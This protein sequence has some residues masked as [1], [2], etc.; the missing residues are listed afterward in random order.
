MTDYVDKV[1]VRVFANTRGAERDIKRVTSKRRQTVIDAV[2]DDAAARRALKKLDDSAVVEVTARTEKARQKLAELRKQ[3]EASGDKTVKVSADITK[4]RAT[5]AQLRADLA[6]TEDQDAKVKIRADIKE[7][8]GRIQ[9]LRAN[10]AGIRAE[11]VAVQVDVKQA[12][13]ELRDLE[14][15][16]KA[17]VQAHAETVA[18]RVEMARVARDRIVNLI[19]RVKSSAAAAE[20]SR[21]IAGL[22]GLK[23]LNRWRQSL[24]N[25]LENLPQLTLKL[26]TFGLAIAGLVTPLMAAASAVAPLLTSLAAMAPLALAYVPLIAA[27]KSIGAVGKLAFKDLDKATS[28]GGKRMHAALEGLKKDFDSVRDVVQDG[29]FSSRFVTTMERLAATVL[30]QVRAGFAGIS[31]ALSSIGVGVMEKLTSQLAGGA[32]ATFFAN[33]SRALSEARDGVIGFTSGLAQIAIAGSQVLPDLGAKLSEIGQRFAA[34]TQHA[35]IAGMI[36]SAAVQFGFLATAAGNLIGIVRGIFTAMDTGRSSG[37]ESL[38]DTLGRIRGVVEG[39]AFQTAMRTVFT[40]AADGARALRE[41]LTPIGDSLAKLAP[42]FGTILATAGGALASML[43]GIT[44]ALAQPI[45]QN[46]IRAALE[47]IAALATSIP[48]GM[49]GAAVGILG[50]AI[51]QIA[52]LVTSLLQSVAPLLPPILAAISSLIPP[53]VRLVQGVLPPLMEVIGALVPVIESLAPAFEALVEP[54]TAIVTM[55]AAGLV[56]ALQLIAKLITGVVVPV[57]QVLGAA[58]TTAVD[59]VTK[60]LSGDWQGAWDAAS[61]AVSAAAG[62]ILGFLAGLVAKALSAIA[63]WASGLVAKVGAMWSAA[64]ALVSSGVNQA[65]SFMASLPGKAAGALAALAS[66]IVGIA[67]TAWARFKAAVSAGVSNVVSFVKGVPGKIKA[68]LGNLGGILLGAGRA[69]MD[70]LLRGLRDAWRKVQDFIG[71]IADWIQKH[72]GPISYDYRLLRPAGDAM[73]SGFRDSLQDGFRD[74]QKLVSGFAPT[75]SATVT[76]STPTSGPKPVAI[77][78]AVRSALDGLGVDLDNGQLFFDRHYSTHQRRLVLDSHLA[79][80]G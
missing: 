73:M 10:L 57:L 47:G 52:P 32:L 60:L 4:A 8:Q 33:V 66:T 27:I 49:L 67:T 77:A 46:G 2:L 76:G 24:V 39:A 20:I 21:I 74:V 43:T 78:E 48:W 71:G 64:V 80:R 65:V 70:G 11:K 59:V 14:K 69:I 23:M 30:P 45:A 28:D 38:A 58:I 6:N 50:Q 54:V 42:L 26:A 12:T 55:L 9:Q 25:M 7:A 5:L 44:D 51:G 53:I 31:V 36:R 41:A 16:R 13:K 40:G 62:A 1:G 17:K 37:L 35:D 79:G 63:A 29:L 72:K 61:A 34:W 18:A 22:S 15:E 3:I 56:A 75:I 68:A 19:V